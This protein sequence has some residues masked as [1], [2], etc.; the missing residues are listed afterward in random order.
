MSD[1]SHWGD[2]YYGALYLDSVA[3]LLT[4]R[5]S[6]LEAAAIR[7]L[8]RLAPGESVL[9]LACGHGRHARVLAGGARVVGLDRSG[10]YLRRAAGEGAPAAF[11]RGDVRALPFRAASFD[12]AYSW[13][14]SLFMFDDAQNEACLS[15]AARVLRP[16]GRLLVHHANPLRLAREPDASARRALPDGS[17]VEEESHYDVARGVDRCARTLVRPGGDRLAGTAELRYYMPTEWG[18]L[19][20]RA[21]LRLVELT[22]TPDA[23]RASRREPGPDSPDLI[24]LLEKPK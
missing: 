7:A 2:A 17:A 3:D 10:A 16:G 15:G 22:T 21:G 5:L 1:G 24:A 19:A 6:A 18:P 14:A 20:R 23:G 11:V 12:A 9:D 13:Y 8:L 4:P